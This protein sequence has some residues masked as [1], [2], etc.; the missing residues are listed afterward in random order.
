MEKEDQGRRKRMKHGERG[1]RKEEEDEGWKKEGG[2]WMK[3]ERKGGTYLHLV[4][5]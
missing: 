1:S 3:S 5:S 4:L 2:G